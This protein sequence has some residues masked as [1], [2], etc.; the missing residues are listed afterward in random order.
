MLNFEKKKYRKTKPY[1]DQ[2]TGISYGFS[3]DDQDTINGVITFRKGQGRHGYG[4]KT[5]G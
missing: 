5:L 3:F 1:G 4:L 2:G